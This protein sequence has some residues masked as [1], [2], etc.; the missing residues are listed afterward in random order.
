[1]LLTTKDHRPNLLTAYHSRDIYVGGLSL[2]NSPMY[3]VY[4][5]DVLDVWLERIAIWV[6]VEAQQEL[7]GRFG[8]LTTGTEGS[9]VA[10]GIP[11][12]PLNTDGI[13]V[14]GRNVTIRDS[15]VECFDDA[16]CA[17][18]LNAHSGIVAGNCTQDMLVE[19]VTVAYGLGLT[20]GSVPPN[21]GV[22]CIRN[23]TFRNATMVKPIKGIYIKPNPGTVGSG[24]IDR[25]TYE[26]VAMDGALW[27]SIY[28]GTQQQ[29]QPGNGT[30]TGCSFWY[31]LPGTTC[32]PQPRVPVTNLVLRNVVSTGS[33]LSPGLLRCANTTGT[34]FTP[35]TG[36]VF[37]NVTMTSA[38]GWPV[39]QTYLCEGIVDAQWVNGSSPQPVCTI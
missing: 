33:L 5:G 12:F 27:W 3:H 18:P 25:I 35:C 20:I 39:G 29:K 16:F 22:N 15:S 11:V 13:D 17:K 21:D 37:D 30:D 32:P 6:D 24:I 31:P 2:C 1:V 26:N 34:D 19:N 38:T 14:A 4:M 7:L 9:G 28:V 8:R 10:A 23:V 36:W